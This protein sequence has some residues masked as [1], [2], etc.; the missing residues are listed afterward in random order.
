[1][2]NKQNSDIKKNPA[3]IFTA[4]PEKSGFTAKLK[5]F[6]CFWARNAVMQ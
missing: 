4:G 6:G 5:S 3:L 1:M 2:N